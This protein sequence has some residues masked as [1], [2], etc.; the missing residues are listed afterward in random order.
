MYLFDFNLNIYNNSLNQRP[1]IKIPETDK[2]I[3]S[4]HDQE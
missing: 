3:Q 4:F 2:F 1:G